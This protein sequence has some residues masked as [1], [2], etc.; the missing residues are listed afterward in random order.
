MST[1]RGH[2]RSAALAALLGGLLCAP[3]SMAQQGDGTDVSLINN[4]WKPRKVPADPARVAQLRVAPGFAVNVFARGLGNPRIIAAG[5]NGDVYVT[6]REHGDILLLRDANRDGVADGPAV[7]VGHRAGTHGIAIHGR[8]LYLVTVKE[9]F[10]ADIQ[11]DGMLGTFRLLAGDLPDAGQHPNRTIAWGP[12]D[13]LWISVG[14][15]CNACNETNPENAAMLRVAPDGKSRVIWAHGL[16]NTIGFDWHPVT[17]ELWGFDH[18]I[19]FLGDDNQ[20][21]ELN[22]IVRARQYGWPHVWGSGELTPWT[23]P[24]GGISKEQWRELSEPMVAGYSAHAAPMQFKFYPGGSFPASYVGDAFTT[25]RGSWNR[26][27]ASGYEIVR[28]RFS[29]GM[30]QSVEPFVSGFLSDGGT[31]HFARPVGLEVARDG[32]LLMADDANGV[33]YRVSY[34]GNDGS[35][36]VVKAPAD[37]MLEQAAQGV[38]VPIAIQRPE[39]SAPGQ[40]KVHLTTAEGFINRRHSEYYDGISPRITWSAAK[41]ARSYVVIMEDPDARPITPFVHWLAWNIPANYRHLPAGLQEQERLLDPPGVIQGR[42]SR[43]SPGYYGPRPPVGDP[44]HRYHFQ[45][46]ALDTRLDVPPGA[47]RDELLA[48]MAGHV[49]A[50]GEAV[51]VYQQT[52][53]PLK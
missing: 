34:T 2:L 37:A 25:M 10:V 24:R 17:G 50:A 45:V 31:T 8:Q 32:A 36:R 43:G 27:P 51:G 19:D 33:I 48:A 11:P 44:P 15:T 14:S 52:V 22:R 41:G 29:G 38:G 26:K 42:T 39:T 13:M 28:V 5:R 35:S 40:L 53:A 47:E 46:F 20:P 1:L 4:V 30:P 9:L 16:R 3:P 49:L 12:D 18:G 21:E 7:W 6:R 23:N